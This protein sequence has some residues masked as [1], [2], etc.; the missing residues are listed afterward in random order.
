SNENGTLSSRAYPMTATRDSLYGNTENFNGLSD[1][2]PAF[3]LYGLD[4]TAT[5]SFTFF[6]SRTGVTDNR[7]TRF[8]VTGGEEKFA[9]LDAANNQTNV[10]VISD[11]APDGAAEITI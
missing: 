10:V 9:D 1:I 6:A 2:A 11:I 8:T 4:A 7:E 3:K 5:Y